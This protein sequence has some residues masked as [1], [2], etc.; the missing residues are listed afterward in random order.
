MKAQDREPSR[1]STFVVSNR[2]VACVVGGEAVILHLDDGVYYSLNPVGA[3]VWDLLQQPRTT[4]ELVARV[5]EEFDVAA[6]RCLLD[7][8]ELISALRERA[9]VVCAEGSG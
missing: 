2:Q 4:E 3:R 5:T 7:V 1:P 8:E 6:E 9:L